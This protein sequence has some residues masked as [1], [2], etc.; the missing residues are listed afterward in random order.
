MVQTSQQKI[1][2]KLLKNSD[3]TNKFDDFLP[4]RYIKTCIK[5]VLPLKCKKKKFDNKKWYKN[6]FNKNRTTQI[7]RNNTMSSDTNCRTDNIQDSCGSGG[8][9]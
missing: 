6:S 1:V 4:W 8:R 9:G 3:I 2:M 5:T 7:N